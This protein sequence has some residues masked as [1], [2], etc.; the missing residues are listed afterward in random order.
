VARKSAISIKID[1]EYNNKDIQKAIRDLKALED[2]SEKTQGV[3]GKFKDL[4][5]A[6]KG[7]I[8]GMATGAGVAITKFAADSVQA[9]SDLDES[10]SKAQ[11]VFGDAS[12]SVEQFGSDAATNLGLSQQA[13]LEATGTFGNLFRAMGIGEGKAAS[14]SQEVVQLAADLASFN[15]IDIQQALDALRS[16]LVGETE[17]LRRL[18]VNLSAARIE[19][20][21][22]ALGLAETK[23][24]LTA[25]SKAQAAWSLITQDSAL[26]AGDFARTSD[27]LANT[28][29]ILTASIDDA[30][31][32]IGKSLLEA[33]QEA[34]QALGG[35]NGMNRLITETARGI[36]D[37]IE[38]VP[39]VAK[40][41]GRQADATEDV[42]E[43]LVKYNDQMV[44]SD[45]TSNKTLRQIAGLIPVI[46]AYAT[47]YLNNAEANNVA[48]QAAKDNANAQKAL[49]A[50]YRASSASAAAA[51]DSLLTHIDA[52]REFEARTGVQVFQ[53]K[54]ANKTY[55]DA[56]VRAYRMA[57]DTREAAEAADKLKKSTGGA[58]SSVEKLTKRQKQYGEELADR[59]LDLL[60]QLRQN[61]QD[62]R[63]EMTNF[64]ESIRQGVNRVFSF[65]DALNTQQAAADRYARTQE[66]VA[67]ATKRVESATAAEAEARARYN[68]VMAD[69]D[70]TASQRES[71]Q[72][73]LADAVEDTATATR[74]LTTAQ[75]EDSVA[76]DEAGKTYLQRL[77]EQAGAAQEFLNTI[78]TLY[79][80]GLRGEA[81][82]QIGS[83]SAE[84][85][86][87]AGQ[88]LIA[89][90]E[91][92]ITESMRL[93]EAT[94]AAAKK[95]GELTASGFYGT[96][97]KSAFETFKGFEAEFGE[98]G[99]SRKRLNRLMDRLAKSMKRETTITVTTI[100]RTINEVSSRF[101][102]FRA[103]GG[104]VSSGTAYVVGE[105]GP[106]LFVPDVSGMI[107]SNSAASPA[108]G[109]VGG[110]VTI[111]VNAGIG[112]NGAE[113]GRQVVEALR[114][115]ERK[116][117]PV[118]VRT[119]S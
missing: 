10:L 20:E 38:I 94:D 61:A 95:V 88:E 74:D 50:G 27:G 117:G 62:A 92:A 98:E 108:G 44:R 97:V 57:E 1:G 119:L 64:A 66:D 31:A 47:A 54:A 42:N 23:D 6:A 41:F 55:R 105:R 28:Q 76:A 109:G 78:V 36:G 116:N 110:G 45:E 112:T 118:P 15:N 26:A 103:N 35:P 2:R 63:E 89:G 8:I 71:V 5:F 81:L 29:R 49:E 56:G 102:G 93:V 25:G 37:L 43:E 67:N 52:I 60:D 101:G 99:T 16:G 100:N 91:G 114:Q 82:K 14:I 77:Q 85:G 24:Q 86:T 111:N 4:S 70:S 51:T 58:A 17:P 72:R 87:A 113:V 75:Q 69:S 80:M 115:Y 53:I 30:Q 13:A 79:E 73:A 39:A 48:E 68:E 22:F 83:M 7:A 32:M 90:G 11:R 65:A 40:A 84:A 3:F 21:A 18:G 46:G 104:P 96:G 19:N 106:E 59:G 33:I 107:V 34:S 9:A 12:A